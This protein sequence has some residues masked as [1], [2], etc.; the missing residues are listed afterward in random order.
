V[1]DILD[2]GETLRSVRETVLSMGAAECRIAVLLEKDIGRSRP[3]SADFVG[4]V[5]PDR[6]VFGCGLDV[7]GAWRNLPE[8]YAMRGN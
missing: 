6:Y 4:L 1:D 7:R 5:V 3:V 2:A 8:I